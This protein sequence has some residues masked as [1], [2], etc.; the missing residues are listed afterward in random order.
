MSQEQQLKRNGKYPHSLSTDGQTQI[1]SK[2][3]EHP[4]E[5]DSIQSK[6][7]RHFLVEKQKKLLEKESAIVGSPQTIKKKISKGKSILSKKST[8]TTRLSKTSV[9]A[10]TSKEK[11]FSPFWNE[12][13]KEKSK[14]LLSCTKTDCVDLDMNSWSLS[15]KNLLAKSWFTAKRINL[16]VPRKNLPKTYFQSS[17]SLSRE[18]MGFVQEKT[19][20]EEKPMKVRKIRLFPNE[21]QR[22]ILNKWFGTARWTYNR[23]LDAINNNV[24]RNK[25]NLRNLCVNEKAFKPENKWV[26][27]T[28]Y[29]I[30]DGA[31]ND[32]LLAYKTNFAKGGE[33]KVKYKSKKAISDSISICKKHWKKN[34]T[35]F[36][37][38]LGTKSLRGAEELPSKLQ[39]DSRLHRT[40]LG[41]FYLCIPEILV[42]RPDSQGS[43]K[44][45]SIDPGVR[46]FCTGYDCSGEILEVGKEDIARIERL[47]YHLDDLQSRLS[48]KD[49]RH[50]KRYRMK[51]AGK[52]LRKRIRNLVDEV[53][54]KL[55]LYLCSKYKIIL[56]PSFD[57]KNMVRKSG[58]RKIT[59]KTVRAMLS[60]S[61]Y[62][63]R[64]RLLNKAREFP[65]CR[66]IVCDE[67]Y[68]SKTCGNCGEL[69]ESLGGSKTFTCKTCE[70]QFDRDHNGA[71][72]ILLRYLTK[73]QK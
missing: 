30:R 61:H 39:H 34:K 4:E 48:D 24:P 19:K 27:E 36:P 46:T 13:T 66:V 52:R 7:F 31:M 40:N 59:S 53:H 72:N 10:S 20:G 62:R 14:K 15:A 26:L 5:T 35:M 54:K 56:L 51:R 17:Q 49:L 57:S 55:A 41:E 42:V 3:S 67:A 8:Q 28:P 2:V 37:T 45:I 73:N 38:Y 22:K 9:A 64:M 58:G 50:R 47:G 33:F 70:C 25:K 23:V 60:W 12:Y 43:Q 11:D 44:I 71:R 18:I 6:I 1:K 63:F 32:V 21:N 68:T 65:D 69:N 29:D 16:K